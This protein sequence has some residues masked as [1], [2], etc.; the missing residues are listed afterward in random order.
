MKN[1]EQDVEL[2]MNVFLNDIR[3]FRIRQQIHQLRR[4]YSKI[5]NN[6]DNVVLILS[7]SE[8]DI[9]KEVI[10]VIQTNSDNN[11]NNEHSN[12]KIS[13][14]LFFKTLYDKLNTFISNDNTNYL[15]NI[16]GKFQSIDTKNFNKEFLI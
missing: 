2:D 1:E 13:F 7:L 14:D 8:H 16:I 5:D 10:K 15:I 9:F 4:I 11:N 3:L 6:K 12:N